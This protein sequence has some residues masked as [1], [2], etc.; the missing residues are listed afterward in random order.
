MVLVTRVDRRAAVHPEA[1]LGADVDIGPFAVI[2]RDAWVST[3]SIVG[4]H[5]V[6]K[7]GTHV[8]ENC[9]I[10][11]HA[12]LGDDPQDLSFRDA[13]SFVEIGAGC[14]IRESVT[15]HRGTQPNSTTR[16]SERCFLMANAHVAHNCHLGPG[17]ILAN[18]VLLGGY[19]EV[20][21][22]AFLSGNAVV[23]Q[24]ARV[25][26]RA[27][28]PGN[29]ALN[30]DLPPFCMAR[31]VMLNAIAGLN[32]V[33]MRRSGMSREDRRAVHEAYRVLY[34]S[35]LSPND[36]VVQ[37]R[38]RFAETGPGAEMA[39]FVEASRRGICRPQRRSSAG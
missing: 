30:K 37:L 18:G 13:P 17:V 16:I 1:Y 28:L 5:A 11:A 22:G 10:H 23:H 20:G 9:R 35:G 6:I 4:A 27:M 21:E 26:R 8:G 31:P 25:G 15:V 2:E 29:A 38:T 36:A 34:R 14:V 7:T 24:F 19:V 3:G 39:R 33:G 12:V 32:V